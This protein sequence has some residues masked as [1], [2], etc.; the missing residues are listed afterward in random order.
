MTGQQQ[1]MVKAAQAP[2][3]I[4]HAALFH[5][6]AS[7][8]AQLALGDILL[9]GWF[10]LGHCMPYWLSGRP[11]P[12]PNAEEVDEAL[13]EWASQIVD[14]FAADRDRLIGTFSCA[15]FKLHCFE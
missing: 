15:I 1:K 14:R 11:T 2:S 8:D 7:I 5:P 9:Q 6:A 12:L 4:Y 13:P 10:I 3:K